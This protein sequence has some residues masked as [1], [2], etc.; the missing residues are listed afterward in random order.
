M[1]KYNI[2][3]NWFPSSLVYYEGNILCSIGSTKNKLEVDLW[4]K[5]HPFYSKESKVIDT[6]GRINSF[7]KKYNIG[8]L[9]NNSNKK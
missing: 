8:L 9:E 4:L 2:H 7:N 5:T 6:E 3:P 1:S